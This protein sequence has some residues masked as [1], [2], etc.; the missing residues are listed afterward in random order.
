ACRAYLE[1]QSEFAAPLE[2]IYQGVNAQ[3]EE[4]AALLTQEKEILPLPDQHHPEAYSV[5]SKWQALMAEVQTLLAA[6]HQSSLLARGI[7]MESLR[8][9]LSFSFSKKIFRAVI[10]KLI[11][12]RVVVREDSTLRLPAHTVKFNENERGTATRLE[13]L[14][15]EGGFTPP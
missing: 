5:A 15:Q 9:Q 3:E 13:Q 6:F 12:E 1:V 8:S 11:S 14:L 7:E 10:D 4:V 2:E